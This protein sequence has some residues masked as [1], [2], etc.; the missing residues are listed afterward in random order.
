M[1][2]LK[3]KSGLSLIFVLAVMLLLLALGVSA[4]TA[5]GLSQGAGRAQRERNQLEMYVT[6][7]EHTILHALQVYY[8][9]DTDSF[10]WGPIGEWIAKEAFDE[11]LY[12]NQGIIFGAGIAL[13]PVQ[14][15]P[16][17]LLH[18]EGVGIGNAEFDIRIRGRATATQIGTFDRFV[19][20]SLFVSQIDATALRV[21]IESLISVTITTRLLTGGL[22]TTTETV[23]R[24]D[25]MR[26]VEEG[27]FGRESPPFFWQMNIADN[28]DVVWEVVRRAVVAGP[29]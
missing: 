24:L 8:D 26:F 22:S 3:N 17:D 9:Q 25:G 11:L 29:N 23:F 18:F 12:E 1:K 15:F 13:V 10:V 21:D 28:N 5:A 2:L 4:L 20:G 27:Y 16:S 14:S 19:P 7:M 6:S